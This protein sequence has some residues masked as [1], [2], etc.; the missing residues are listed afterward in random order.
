MFVALIAIAVA[1]RANARGA[2]IAAAVVAA[3]AGVR[4]YRDFPALDRSGEVF[5]WDPI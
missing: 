5:S 4:A 2:A 1:V 3:Y